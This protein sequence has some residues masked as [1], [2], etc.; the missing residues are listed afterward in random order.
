MDRKLVRSSR[1]PGRRLV[2]R[3]WRHGTDK[4]GKRKFEGSYRTKKSDREE[5]TKI[6]QEELVT[7]T[8][9]SRVLGSD[10]ASRQ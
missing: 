1:A 6:R 9:T 2:L 5:R 8:E 7:I 4:V 10:E 3:F